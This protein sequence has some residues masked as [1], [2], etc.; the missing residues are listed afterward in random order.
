M[1]EKVHLF[2]INAHQRFSERLKV[3]M[4]YW[5][6]QSISQSIS[7]SGSER[8]WEPK[9][10]EVNTAAI[11]CIDSIKTKE[12]SDL[13]IWISNKGRRKNRDGSTFDLSNEICNSILVW[14]VKYLSVSI[15]SFTISTAIRTLAR[16]VRFPVRVWLLRKRNS[17]DITAFFHVS[18]IKIEKMAE[19][20]ENTHHI[21]LGNISP[22]YAS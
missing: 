18:V 22:I 14:L 7:W 20:L 15:F 9:I 11:T 16:A 8:V 1:K 3:I 2:G 13:I 4:Y 6:N 17:Y 19:S 5:I 12:A 10:S 21:I